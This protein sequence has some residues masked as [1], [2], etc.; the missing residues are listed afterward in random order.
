MAGDSSLP[1]RSDGLILDNSSVH[2]IRALS[3]HPDKILD[4]AFDLRLLRAVSMSE[5]LYCSQI[6]D[7][8]GSIELDFV[9]VPVIYSDLAEDKLLKVN[10]DAGEGFWSGRSF[11]VGDNNDDELEVLLSKL[12]HEEQLAFCADAGMS[13]L[14]PL[15]PF[16]FGSIDM[17]LVRGVD[18]DIK[19]L[20]TNAFFGLEYSSVAYDAELIQGEYW[21]DIE[22]ISRSKSDLLRT[23][24]DFFYLESLQKYL[25]S[26]GVDFSRDTDRAEL[27]KHFTSVVESE[28]QNALAILDCRVNFLKYFLEIQPLAAFSSDTQT[29][30]VTRANPVTGADPADDGL[31]AS[32]D[33][34]RTTQVILN[35]LPYMPAPRS[36]AEAMKLRQDPRV[37]DVRSLISKWSSPL[38]EGDGQRSERIL[39]EVEKASKALTRASYCSAASS[40]ATYLS[41]PASIAH[42]AIPVAAGISISALGF[43]ACLVSGHVRR[44]N[45]WMFFGDPVKRIR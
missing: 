33:Y 8:D 5:R 17:S 45:Q 21:H 13:L 7:G 29:P 4:D 32:E 10:V 14:R 36:Y 23:A 9:P 37:A 11:A 18:L 16:C 24:S 12:H 2:R 31:G 15:E 38:S 6:L 27:L 44:K 26:V 40:F 19:S 39:R 3:L 35:Q 25:D 34:F 43:A 30:I 1:T 42:S 22:N 28:Y 41:L 20:Y